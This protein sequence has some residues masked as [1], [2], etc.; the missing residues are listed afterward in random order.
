MITN[1]MSDRGPSQHQRVQLSG[2]GLMRHLSAARDAYKASQ[3]KFR[4]GTDNGSKT[5]RYHRRW[6]KACW[7]DARHNGI[8][9]TAKR[10]LH[11]LL[12]AHVPRVRNDVLHTE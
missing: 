9:S 10:T 5:V 3:A 7:S 1:R 4:H 2:P 8:K 6:F 12:S 11:L